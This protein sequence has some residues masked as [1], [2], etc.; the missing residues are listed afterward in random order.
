MK[1]IIRDSAI[2]LAMVLVNLALARDGIPQQ[3]RDH[4][5][6]S[7]TV[8]AQRG[9]TN[10]AL[11]RPSETVP[12]RRGSTNDALQRPS[13]TVPAQRGSTNEALQRPSEDYIR[14]S[15]D[16]SV[17]PADF[18]NWLNKRMIGLQ[19]IAVSKDPDNGRYNFIFTPLGS[20]SWN[21]KV[22]VVPERDMQNVLIT[23]LRQR[24]RLVTVMSKSDGPRGLQHICFFRQI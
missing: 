10:D 14:T 13:E 19:L 8:P 20:R 23:M 22:M 18:E 12:A 17:I 2:C 3:I 5:K 21:Y 4:R 1:R 6:P 9:S 7:E 24:W 16:P 11:Q 15:F